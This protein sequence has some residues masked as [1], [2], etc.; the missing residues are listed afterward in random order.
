MYG[1]IGSGKQVLCFFILIFQKQKKA[2]VFVYGS[3]LFGLKKEVSADVK[4]L[5][6]SF[7]LSFGLRMGHGS[8]YEAQPCSEP[9]L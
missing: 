3:G 2:F 6:L 1:D 5:G 8:G 9:S 4:T 7:G